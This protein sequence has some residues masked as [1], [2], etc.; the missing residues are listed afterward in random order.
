[1]QEKLIISGGKKISGELEIA[2]AKNSVLKQMAASLLFAGPLCIKNV[3]KLKDVENMV[4]V[5]EFLGAKTKFIG[6]DLE[7]DSKD[8]SGVFAPH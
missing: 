5:L 3:P 7:I 4:E 6:N 1:M 2:S 8:V